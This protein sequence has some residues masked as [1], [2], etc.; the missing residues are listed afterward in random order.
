MPPSGSYR[1]LHLFSSLPISQFILRCR[2]SFPHG[3]RCNV[4]IVAAATTHQSLPHHQTATLPAH[5]RERHIALKSRNACPRHLQ[6]TRV[7]I[8]MS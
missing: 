2:V 4:S 3:L 8:G 7:L 6:T 5:A 1:L